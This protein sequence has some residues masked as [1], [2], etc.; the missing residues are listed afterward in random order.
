MGNTIA[1]RMFIRVENTG[2][3][4]SPANVLIEAYRITE[5]N[6]NGYA[7][8]IIFAQNEVGLSE[9]GS[10]VNETGPVFVLPVTL[11]SPLIPMFGSNY[12]FS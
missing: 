3:G 4:N 10:D 9:F 11:N 6:P 2:V 8:Q 5:P 1:Q 7:Q 12:N